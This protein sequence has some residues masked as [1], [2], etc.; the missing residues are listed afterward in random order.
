M[1]FADLFDSVGLKRLLATIIIVF[2]GVLSSIPGTG[3]LISFLQSIAAILGT[4]GLVHAA[5][6]KEGVGIGKGKVTG[7]TGVTLS[8]IMAIVVIIFKVI[9]ALQP[10]LEVV[11]AIA[12]LLGATTFALYALKKE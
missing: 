8:S 5:V 4:V 11:Q 12:S 2:I 6:K 3:F 7:L 9:P 10:Y 1:Q